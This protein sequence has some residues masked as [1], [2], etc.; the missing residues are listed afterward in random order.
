MG[1]EE[2]LYWNRKKDKKGKKCPNPKKKFKFCKEFIDYENHI[3]DKLSGSVKSLKRKKEKPKPPI[4]YI[5]PKMCQ[6]PNV[7]NITVSFRYKCKC[8]RELHVLAPYMG[9][10]PVRHICECREV[11]KYY[12]LVKNSENGFET[13][14]ILEPMGKI[15]LEKNGK[16]EIE[17]LKK[18]K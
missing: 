17:K 6:V 14:I 9:K 16:M 5:K 4:V 10:V 11:L 18:N 15:E 7:S 1:C 13:K 3:V 2:C 12:F 8:G